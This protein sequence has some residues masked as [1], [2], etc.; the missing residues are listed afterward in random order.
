M[1]P[2]T[3]YIR[4]YSDSERYHT[5]VG[6]TSD[7]KRRQK[8]HEVGLCRTTNRFNKSYRLVQIR[9][10]VTNMAGIMEQKLKKYNTSQRM[11][12]SADWQRWLE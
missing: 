3:V 9:Y 8:E 2:T 6:I 12:Y 10:K 11:K 1:I 5:Y 4:I 7:M